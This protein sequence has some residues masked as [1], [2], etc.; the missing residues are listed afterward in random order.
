MVTVVLFTFVTMITM[1]AMVVVVTMVTL[2]TMVIDSTHVDRGTW[3]ILYK[4]FVK[5]A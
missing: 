1:V 3:E 2:T 5:S 4:F